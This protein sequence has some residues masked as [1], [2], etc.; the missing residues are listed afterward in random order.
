M[1]RTA[2]VFI[3]TRRSWQTASITRVLVLRQEEVRR[4]PAPSQGQDDEAVILDK[5]ARSRIEKILY[6]EY[7]EEPET[8]ERVQEVWERAVRLA[9][10]RKAAGQR[11]SAHDLFERSMRSYWKTTVFHRYGGDVWLQTLI[12]TGRVHA[13]S[14]G[15][16]NEIYAQRMRDAGREPVSDPA[17]AAPQSEGR[18]LAS[19]QGHVVVG[20][21]HMK[22]HT[23]QL[24]DAARHADKKKK[25]HDE[26]WWAAHGR[27]LSTRAAEWWR[28]ESAQLQEEADRQWAVANEE[29]DKAGTPY[30]GRDGGAREKLVDSYGP[31]AYLIRVL[32]AQTSVTRALY[33]VLYDVGLRV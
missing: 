10:E 20:V 16:V 11:A 23:G 33:G 29:S 12:A 14:V 5:G 19:S 6:Q 9:T 27:G 31:H 3:V 15:I 26:N 17:S 8:Q 2:D 28:W 30:K 21:Q 18:A 7:L 25:W 32:V 13:V 24:R 22:K 1:E 4:A